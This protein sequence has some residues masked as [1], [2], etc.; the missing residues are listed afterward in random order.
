MP[1]SQKGRISPPLASVFTDQSQHRLLLRRVRCN[2]VLVEESVA[3]CCFAGFSGEVPAT[4]TTSSVTD[5]RADASCRYLGH[6]SDKEHPGLARSQPDSLTDFECTT[7]RVGEALPKW[8]FRKLD[9]LASLEAGLFVANA[10]SHVLS[11]YLSAQHNLIMSTI[12]KV[13]QYRCF[14]LL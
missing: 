4:T 10:C 11:P 3:L 14:K 13:S 2:Y 8:T 6:S 9:F 7:V 12:V 5:F 1:G